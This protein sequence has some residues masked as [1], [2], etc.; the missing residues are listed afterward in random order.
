MKGRISAWKRVLL[1]VLFAV[2]AGRCSVVASAE[3]RPGQEIKATLNF[4]YDNTDVLIYKGLSSN[5]LN[6][7]VYDVYSRGVRI[8]EIRTTEVSKYYTRATIL[9]GR[10]TPYEWQEIKLVLVSAPPEEEE[11]PEAVAAP[12]GRGTRG[13]RAAE[14]PVVREEERGREKEPA[15]VPESEPA[16]AAQTAKAQ[17][18]KRSAPAQEQ[19]E[20]MLETPPTEDGPRQVATP[21][22]EK[23][24]DRLVTTIFQ[25]ETHS[26]DAGGDNS[27]TAII[28]SSKRIHDSIRTVY[29]MH[30]ANYPRRRTTD[31]AVAGFSYTQFFNPTT[32]G[33]IGYSY[34]KSERP[35]KYA[36]GAS[37]NVN[38]MFGV[39]E[40]KNTYYQGYA[41]Y[42]VS[43]SFRENGIYTFGLML[44]HKMSDKEKV[45][46]EYKQA[47]RSGSGNLH[48]RLSVD[49]AFPFGNG[50][51]LKVGYL[52]TS[53]GD[54]ERD[55]DHDGIFRITLSSTK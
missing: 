9:K 2:V 8:G 25:Y 35:G 37:F 28:S 3:A 38:K 19:P 44:H 23:P 20:I 13:E 5:I 31:A 15:P 14:T 54:S 26:D 10:F 47:H 34:S 7:A 50:K 53:Y 16:P 33:S 52:Y 12:A 46:L 49:Y 27:L 36:D 6:D 11:E 42:S 43:D 32:Y 39:G 30:A 4:V 24:D 29:L 41:G 55:P 48:N 51:K 45:V 1:T 17:R 40:N 22:P 18:S 21:A